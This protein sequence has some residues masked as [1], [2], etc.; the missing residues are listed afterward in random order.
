MA[1][2]WESRSD[3]VRE[4]EERKD[5]WDWDWRSS[6][7]FLRFCFLASISFRASEIVASDV[8]A[9]CRRRK[10]TAID[11]IQNYQIPLNQSRTQHR[12]DSQSIGIG[13]WTLI[14]ALY[15]NG[16]G[17]A[18]ILLLPNFYFIFLGFKNMKYE[19]SQKEII[20]I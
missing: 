4:K 7:A 9:I 15:T 12:V 2:K 13:L 1:V 3:Q 11:K 5:D 16:Y 18:Q 8:A 10:I 14:H 6:K 17:H 19:S 20:I